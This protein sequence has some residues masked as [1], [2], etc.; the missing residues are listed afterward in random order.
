[1]TMLDT[2]REQECQRNRA[3]IKPIIDT[4][5]FCGENELP[6]RGDTDS[7]PLTMEKP[8]KKDGNFRALLRFRADINND[9]RQ[10]I[11]NCP[12]NASYL[13]P[14]IQN[15]IINIC[16]QLIQKKF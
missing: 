4:I 6:L 12:R 9:L 14:D 2:S 3:A 15:E 1:M 7:G 5:I 11:I 13:S 16:G 8:R 10:N